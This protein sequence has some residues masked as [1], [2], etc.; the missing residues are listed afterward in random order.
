L[1]EQLISIELKG[2]IREKV[3]YKK[4]KHW[5]S[6]SRPGNRLSWDTLIHSSPNRKFYWEKQ[7][8]FCKQFCDEPAGKKMQVMAAFAIGLLIFLTSYKLHVNN[9]F[10]SD[11]HLIMDH[12][13]WKVPPKNLTSRVWRDHLQCCGPQLRTF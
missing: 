9:E 7:T 1:T 13:R 8:F 3:H 12:W 4:R 6:C 2:K 11:V 5:K 10:I